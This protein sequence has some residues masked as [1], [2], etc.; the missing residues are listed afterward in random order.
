MALVAGLGLF[1]AGAAEARIVRLAGRLEQAQGVYEVRALVDTDSGSLICPDNCIVVRAPPGCAACICDPVQPGCNADVTLALPHALP[2]RATPLRGRI[3]ISD[4]QVA[5][6]V[7]GKGSVIVRS[8]TG[9]QV[10]V[11][12]RPVP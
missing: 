7:A 4:A 6:L 3:R 9:K 11:P 10:R 12:L 5:D 1:A 2:V 8:A